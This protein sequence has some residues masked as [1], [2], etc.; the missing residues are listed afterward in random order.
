MA[1]TINIIGNN[2]RRFLWG[3]ILI[4]RDRES[5]EERIAIIEGNEQLLFAPFAKSGPIGWATPT[6]QV[7]RSFGT[8]RRERKKERKKKDKDANLCMSTE[9]GAQREIID[10]Q[11]QDK[12]T[13]ASLLAVSFLSDDETEKNFTYIDTIILH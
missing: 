3:G 7:T 8:H 1:R 2:E 5:I 11:C 9:E 12:S 10:A 6:K 4:I 13:D